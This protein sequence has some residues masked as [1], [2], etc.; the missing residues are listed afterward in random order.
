M[1]LGECKPSQKIAKSNFLQLHQKNIKKHESMKCEY[2]SN[3][4]EKKKSESIK[5]CWSA[6]TLPVSS[7]EGWQSWVKLSYSCSKI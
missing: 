7:D 5:V 1:H 3:C 4:V 6:Q 2:F